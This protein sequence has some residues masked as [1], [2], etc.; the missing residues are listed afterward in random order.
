MARSSDTVTRPSLGT[1][2]GR[3]LARSDV[4]SLAMR[5]PVTRWMARRDGQE[6]FEV[7]QGFVSSQVLVALV[8]LDIFDHLADGPMT[9]RHLAHRLGVNANRLAVFLH[10]GAALGFLRVHRGDRYGLSRK[11]AALRGVPGLADMILHHR[12]LYRDLESPESFLRNGSETELSGFWPYVGDAAQIGAE[13]AERYSLLMAR[14]QRLVAEDTLRQVRLKNVRHLL[15]IGGG[16]GAFLAEVAQR[17]PAPRLTLFDLPQTRSAAQSYLEGVGQSDR[18]TCTSGSFA[19]DPLPAGADAISLIRVLY[20]HDDETVHRLFA[21][22]FDALPPGGR[23]IISEPM[24]GG[25]HP[26]PITDVYFAI[27]TLAMG[28]GKTRSAAQISELLAASGF[29]QIAHP[30]PLRRYITSVVTAIKPG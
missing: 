26:D 5:L 28:T 9:A 12:A 11:G 25:D 3:L 7:V 8:A 18:I 21:K 6:I 19:R 2:F 4:Q 27:Y 17:Y 13:Q 1:W 16:S 29:V 30:K 22:V 24:S 15:D 23:L 14:S 10:A 20:D